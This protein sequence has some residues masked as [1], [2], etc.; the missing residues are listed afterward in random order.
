MLIYKDLKLAGAP[1]VLLSPANMSAILPYINNAVLTSFP[2]THEN[3]TQSMAD[4]ITS[5]GFGAVGFLLYAI[6]PLD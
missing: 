3:I 4:W 2:M 1:G 5:Q 6:R